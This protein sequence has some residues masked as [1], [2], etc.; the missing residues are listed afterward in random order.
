MSCS[1]TT[2][3]AEHKVPEVSKDLLRSLFRLVLVSTRIREKR[4]GRE[5]GKA[6][7]REISILGR[8]SAVW[9]TRQF[10]SALLCFILVLL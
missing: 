8:R 9:G 4:G 7:R 5:G 3:Y 1:M 2:G 10:F 6:I